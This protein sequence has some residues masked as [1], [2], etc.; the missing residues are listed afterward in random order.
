MTN[1]NEC[2][3]VVKNEIKSFI[4]I[5]C[6]PMYAFINFFKSFIKVFIAIESR[7]RVYKWLNIAIFFEKLHPTLF[8]GVR[9][10]FAA[11]APVRWRLRH[12]AHSPKIAMGADERAFCRKIRR[13]R[14]IVWLPISCVG[15]Q[16]AL[17][18]CVRRSVW[19]HEQRC[20]CSRSVSGSVYPFG[21]ATKTP[22]TR[23]R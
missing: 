13:R 1:H 12:G 3:I 9:S 2:A 8:G 5:E 14:I 15:P 11:V 23:S 4:Y 16:T 7:K 20:S 19:A 6:M 10:R 18:G 22:L 17:R 21:A